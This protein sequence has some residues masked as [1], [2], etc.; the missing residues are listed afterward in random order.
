MQSCES[1]QTA[2]IL[3]CLMGI[4]VAACSGD[5]ET[6]E[7]ARTPPEQPQ[8]VAAPS[9]SNSAAEILASS[10]EGGW[11]NV[12]LLVTSDDPL[13]AVQQCVE[14]HSGATSCYAFL[15][16]EAYQTAEPTNAGNFRLTCWAARWT[17][18]KAGSTSGGLNQF[19]P[20]GC[21][22]SAKPASSEGADDASTEAP[23]TEAFELKLTL[24]P[25]VVSGD[26]IL[27]EGV[28]NLPD[29]TKVSTSV[30]GGSFMGQDEA[31]VNGGKWRSGPFGP[32]TGLAPG[33]YEASVTLPYGR[34][35]PEAVQAQLGQRLENLTGPLM[36]TNADLEFMGQTANVQSVVTI[37]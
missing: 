33:S 31:V 6:G 9:L 21:P 19:M 18:N 25:K 1:R 28:T 30:S 3:L 17:R 13:E 15:T 32:R 23:S 26:R 8:G 10:T 16:R 34:T 12:D 7:G 29:G 35:Q 5:A 14:S 2:R 4:S 24:D 36:K 20:A 11:E 27:L 37:R 22:A